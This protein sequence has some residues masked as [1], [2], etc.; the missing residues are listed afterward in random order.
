MTKYFYDTEFLDDGVTIDMISIG[1]VADDG[2]EYYAVNQQA[3]W[4]AIGEHKWLQDNVIP[5]LPP[6]SEWKPR[7]QIANEVA[8]FL[9]D[10]DTPPELW[11][12]FAA[13]DHVAFSQLFGRMLD[14]PH[15]IPMYT[16]DL[17]SVID[18]MPSAYRKLPSQPSSTIHDALEDARFLKV[19]C[20]FVSNTIKENNLALTI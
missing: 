15:G 5:H 8:K 3:D 14:I 11:A 7:W 16:N 2:R 9:L 20:E 12:W 18:F 13:Y 10:G 6:E 19:R 17:R 1:I 4:T